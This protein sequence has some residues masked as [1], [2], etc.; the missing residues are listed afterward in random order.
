MAHVLHSPGNE[1]KIGGKKEGEW[2]A[3][4]AKSQWKH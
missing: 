2:V 4:R 3:R 1:K